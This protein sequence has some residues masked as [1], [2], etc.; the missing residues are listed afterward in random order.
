M[1]FGYNHIKNPEFFQENRMKAHSDHKYYGSELELL[2]GETSFKQSLN[3]L[4]FFSY[5]KNI[6]STIPNFEVKEYDC[7]LWDQ[8]VVPA[9]IQLEGYDLPQ[10]VNVQY[11]W[12]GKQDLAI[13]EVPVDFN[14]VASYAKYFTVA[15]GWNNDK[16]FISF[17]GVESGFALWL[18]GH[19][20]GYSEDT[21]TPSEFELSP[22][23]V[24]GE[25]K[26]A[27][28]VFKWTSSSWLEDQD[29]FRFSGIF[30]DVYLYTIPVT[31]I[32]DLK[33]LTLLDDQYKNSTLDLSW[34][35]SG[36]AEGIM[37]VK[38]LWKNEVVNYHIE[39]LSGDGHISIP[40]EE[41]RL[42]SAEEPNLYQ[43]YLTLKN[44]AGQVLEI[45]SQKLGFR[46]F[47][48]KDGLMYLNGKR[49]VFKG[50]NRHEFGCYGGRVVSEE[51]MITDIITMK[52]HNINAVRTSHY[53]NQSRF[54]ELC[55]E[56]GLYM[57]N[58]TNL[59]TH[60]TGR[61]NANGLDVNQ[62]LPGDK[63]EW[64]EVVLDR[65]E[66]LYQ[67]DKNHPAVLI[68]SCGNEAFGGKNI[69]EMSQK[70]RAL[71]SSRLVHYEGIFNDRRY[72][73]TSDIESQ[74]YTT[75]DGIKEF[76]QKN[77][78]K[79]FICC[80]YTHAMGN[81]CGAMD[82]Y[83]DLT[84]TEPLYQGGFIWDYIDQSLVKKDRYGKEYHGFGGDF[85][86][87]PNDGNFSGN[88]IVYG[89]RKPSPKMQEV[90]FNYQNISIKIDG[91]K[92]LV[93][94]KNL[95]TN[96]NAFDCAA[97]LLRNGKLIASY[98][99]ET[100]VAPLSEAEY[101]LPMPTMEIH[102]EYVVTVAFT[103]KEDTIWAKK[104]HEVAFGQGVYRI[105]QPQEKEEQTVTIIESSFCIGVK[106][107]NFETIFTR[108]GGLTSYRYGGV[109]LLASGPRPNFWRAPIDNDCGNH[110]MMRYAQ[111]KTASLYQ[112]THNPYGETIGA[113]P[114]VER[115][116]GRAILTYTYYLA[117][118]PVSTCEVC[119][120][121]TGDGVISMKLS[122]DP[123]EGLSEMPEFGMIFKIEAD[124]DQLEWYGNGPEESYCDRSRGARLGIYRNEV[125]DNM[126]KYLVPQECG[127]K[128]EVR[129][130]KVTNK[131]GRGL[132][133][134]GDEIE[135]SAL[136]YT[137]HE[138]EN[139]RHPF[140]LPAV[141]H[142]VIRANKQQMGV[143]GDNS[144]GARTHDEYLLDISKK[145]EF[146]FSIQGIV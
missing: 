96:T 141:H 66:S 137:P 80:E 63:P 30:R 23:L 52:Q 21:F 51:D 1:K 127:N 121:I 75:A 85:Y 31:H 32:Y 139:A 95:F 123:V 71:D 84:D 68:W 117:T 3:G 112:T 73:D 62:I 76:L 92:V 59:E 136:P 54:Y 97:T 126:A 90:K 35:L 17:Q 29:F 140:E 74:M 143:G 135:F 109:E 56:Y 120:E 12:E 99:I 7:K 104:G 18:N 49:I 53:P 60:G 28:Q 110:M 26:L 10:Y 33:V 25:N 38:L 113:N 114:K 94:N 116:E 44:P 102:G 98:P 77:P 101:S 34:V 130:A 91:H 36:V 124:Y 72:N 2:E 138:M 15:K 131:K 118:N 6:E 67:R 107:E 146:R 43:L 5:A 88:G 103:L 61:Y 45:V 129:Y 89:N 14:P 145:I 70:Y 24:E 122:Y 108:S 111:W 57:I 81:S 134:K 69:Y 106:G 50:T 142:T 119:Y 93:I 105:D 78:N 37:E 144:W 13:G 46:R 86:D 55:D 39:K 58:E 4:W 11:P 82:K 133:I 20:V 79:P 65:V 19:Y 16:V 9:H 8:I 128:T 48:L 42:W 125:Q 83:T 47:E 115:E 100:A 41:P 132:L 64:L 40:V 27:V 22:Y 87:Q